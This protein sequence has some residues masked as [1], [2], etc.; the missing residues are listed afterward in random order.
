MLPRAPGAGELTDATRP[1]VQ[2]DQGPVLPAEGEVYGPETYETVM[3]TL[4]E[5]ELSP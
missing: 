1:P 2:M 5:P 3:A 4:K